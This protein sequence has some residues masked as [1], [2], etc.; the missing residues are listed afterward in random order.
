M[1]PEKYHCAIIVEYRFFFKLLVIVPSGNDDLR[2]IFIFISIDISRGKF[3]LTH[4]IRILNSIIYKYF[5]KNVF[6]MRKARS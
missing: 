3:F 5:K 2:F 4:E 1:S 6:L